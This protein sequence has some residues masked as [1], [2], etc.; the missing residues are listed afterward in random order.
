MANVRYDGAGMPVAIVGGGSKEGFKTQ[1]SIAARLCPEVAEAL[2]AWRKVCPEPFP[3]RPTILWRGA[4]GEIEPARSQSRNSLRKH[5]KRLRKKW[6]LPSLRMYDLRHWIVTQYR[7][8]DLSRQASAYLMGHDPTRGGSMRDWYDNPALERIFAEQAEH[9][10]EET[11]ATLDPVRLET[12]EGLCPEPVDLL[13]DYLGGRMG[14]ME[15]ATK[16]ESPSGQDW[17]LLSLIL[18]SPSAFWSA[19]LA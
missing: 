8:P 19:G 10:P 11:L 3:E 2:G 17:T 5:W 18:L 6:Q 16:I 13:R 14:T 15:F 7:R 4:N 1:S 9:L 12:P